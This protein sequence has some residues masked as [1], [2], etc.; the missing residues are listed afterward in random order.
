MSSV[1]YQNDPDMWARVQEKP[2]LMDMWSLIKGFWEAP[3]VY[4]KKSAIE[5]LEE[6]KH[7]KYGVIVVMDAALAQGKQ[8]IKYKDIEDAVTKIG[9]Q[10]AFLLNGDDEQKAFAHKY[11]LR[12]M[13]HLATWIFTRDGL[14]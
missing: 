14:P 1:F 4:D 7:G 12:F 2:E 10:K 9:I 13:G 3:S 5:W 6:N 8:R 11:K